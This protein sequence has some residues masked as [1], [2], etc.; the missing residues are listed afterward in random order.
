MSITPSGAAAGPTGNPNAAT[1]NASTT[2]RSTKKKGFLSFLCCGV[3]DV[4]NNVND[5][6]VPA[7]K[8]SKI[9]AGHPSTASRPDNV[10]QQA[11]AQAQTEKVAFKQAEPQKDEGKDLQSLALGEPN[12][13]ISQPE[14]GARDQPLPDLPKEAESSAS[15]AGP[16]NP[17]VIVQGP[18]RAE[19]KRVPATQSSSQDQKDGE[20]DVRMEDPE[21]LPATEKEERAVSVPRKDETATKTVLPPPPPGP[22]PSEEASAPDSA[23]QKQTWL[24]PPIADRFKGKKCLVL[25]LDETLVHSSFKVRSSIL[26]ET[27]VADETL[28]SAPGGLHD[29]CRD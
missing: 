23:E 15:P 27:F 4:S 2:N 14:S 19:S 13:E 26:L 18:T 24:L 11:S 7:K 28:D 21:P 1:S 12:G 29:S 9:G 16:E 8:V 22:A 25:D 6:D 17:S 5:S 20:G 3:P 10:M